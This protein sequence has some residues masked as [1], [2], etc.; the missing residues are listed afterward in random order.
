MAR[1][2]V[3]CRPYPRQ[4]P[5]ALTRTLGSVRGGR[6]N[7]VSTATIDE[8][9]KRT[10]ETGRSSL[11]RP[12]QPA[13]VGHKYERN[14]TVNLFMLFAA[15][16]RMAMGEGHRPTD[17]P[18]LGAPGPRTGGRGL[19]REEARSGDEQL[20]HPRA[21]L[22]AQAFELAEARRIVERLEIHYTPRHG[23][24]LN[25]A[26]IR[27]GVLSRQCLSRRIPYR[28]TVPREVGVRQEWRNRPNAAANR[29]FKTGDARIRL[30][31]LCPSM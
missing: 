2:S 27:I 4:E 8:T 5:S 25:I 28:E 12:G 16:A 22:A 29:R 17:A 7:P 20:D 14:G 10:S 21:I 6:G 3:C 31:S 30:N 11:V 23:S 19:F 13:I 1:Y 15:T 9:S 18:R 24:W 26:E